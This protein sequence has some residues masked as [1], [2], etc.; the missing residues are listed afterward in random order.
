MSARDEALLFVCDEA[1]C[2]EDPMFYEIFSMDDRWS[3]I[4]AVLN[5]AEAH[6]ATDRAPTENAGG[7]QS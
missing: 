6:K 3:I 4:R 5:A 7:E 1:A 2:H